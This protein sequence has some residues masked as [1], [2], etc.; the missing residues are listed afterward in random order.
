MPFK[1]TIK[2]KLVATLCIPLLIMA[3][4]FIYSLIETKNYV[5]EKEKENVQI[6]LSDI[7]NDNLKGQ[8]D[9]L[10]YAITGYYGNTKVEN[11][12]KSL[13]KEMSEFRSTVKKIYDNSPS[14][15]AAELNVYAFLNQFRWNGGR[16]LFAYNATTYIAKAY[17]SDLNE[18]DKNG[19]DKKGANGEYFVRDVIHAAQLSD[20]GFSEYTFINPITNTV[21][22]KITASFY[23][24]PLDLVVASGEYISTLRKHN[25]EAALH[26]VATAKYGE[27][28]YFWVQDKDGTII[29]H[30]KADIIGTKTDSTETV[31]EAIK[32]KDETIVN[33]V[34]E[35]PNTK[36]HENKLTYARKIFPEWDW[37]IAT[38]AY[39]SDIIAVQDN[40]TKV[41][42]NIFDDQVSTVITSSVILI[43]LA[44]LIAIW[45]I[46]TI[47]KGLLTLKERIDTLSTGEADLTSRLAIVN[48]DELGEISHS[49]NRF[50]K[51]LQSM[52]LDISQASIHITKSTEQLNQQSSQVNKALITHAN[53]TDQVVSAITEM[54][55]TS[56]SVAQNATET[57]LNTQKANDEAL[58][59]KAIVTEASNSVIALVDEVDSASASI[60]TM[61]D[62][63]QQIIKALS[64][65]GAIADQTNL[66]ALNAAIEAARAGEQGRGFAVVADEVR[67]LAA[68]TQSSTAEINL[69][70]ATLSNDA[71]NAVAAMDVTKAS[72]QRTAENT[73]RVTESLDKMTNFIIHI[74]DLTA[75]I[76][77]A[78]EEQSSVT[79]EVNRNMN[80]ISRMVQELTKSGQVTLD[81]T[82][83]LASANAQLDAL[84][85]KFKLR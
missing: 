56:D 59:S 79:E 22:N 64:V 20:I 17:G 34:Y 16:Y 83:N 62:N 73:A 80:N 52:M 43:A 45:I 35:N 77:T 65:I 38:G 50:I 10:T 40:L 41:T 70:L 42:Q 60:N 15:T 25:I 23:F 48:D 26:A 61:S 78:S 69:I 63:T 85:H 53:E 2:T 57:A 71:S 76:A 8:I 28:G 19:Y 12:K 46:V 32:E 6:K 49:V 44:S 82:Q 9:T 7:V 36:Q 67:S 39:E 3:I 29:S 68:R 24:E 5:L 13:E 58:L 54:S 4:F 31:A 30:P 51:F 21:E 47:V 14:D 37:T 11:I 75:Q 81:S 1:L 18:V 55:S 66:L 74:N 33:V 84:V 72:C 27:N